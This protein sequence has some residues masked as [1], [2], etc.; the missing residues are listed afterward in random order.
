MT[1]A[2]AC[3]GQDGLKAASD[4]GASCS[5]FTAVMKETLIL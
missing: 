1:L 2:M 3:V 4:P 5:A